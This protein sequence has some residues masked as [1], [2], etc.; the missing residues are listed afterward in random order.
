M[1]TSASPLQRAVY[2][3][4]EALDELTLGDWRLAE[5][6]RRQLEAART[7]IAQVA[8]GQW[9]ARTLGAVRALAST[10]AREEALAARFESRLGTL[11]EQ[12]LREA[13]EQLEHSFAAVRGASAESAAHLAGATEDLLAELR[14]E[15]AAHRAALLSGPMTRFE[16]R[17]VDDVVAA[18]RAHG[19][20]IEQLMLE[21]GEAAECA[22]GTPA[23]GLLPTRASHVPPLPDLG[24]ISVG[25]AARRTDEVSAAVGR[26]MD[27]FCDRLAGQI[28]DA[29]ETLRTRVDSATQCHA[30][31]NRVA[32]ERA[33]NLA[34]AAHRLTQLSEQLDRMLL[35]DG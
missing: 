12:Q 10:A 33:E 19:D 16:E 25:D 6:W 14:A 4:R 5:S 15:L 29:I 3:T 2:E 8:D 28:E 7:W 13:S 23:G 17:F 35:D 34:R 27:V 9:D 20:R 21:L 22:V 31:E 11:S 18:M 30:A 1:V 26:S 24:Y 32:R